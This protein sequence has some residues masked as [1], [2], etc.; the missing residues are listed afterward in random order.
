MVAQRQQCTA[1]LKNPDGKRGQ[2]I[3]RL[4]PIQPGG[5]V[6]LAIR[7]VVAVLRVPKL[8]TRAQQGCALGQQ[9]GGQ[10]C[11][12]QSAPEL[13]DHRIIAGAFNAAVEAEVIAMAVPVVFAIGFI[14]AMLVGHQIPQREAVVRCHVV[15]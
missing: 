10:Q 11:T 1:Q 14:A 8:G 5:G 9:S 2:V 12:L 6:V 15:H 4:R 3:I 7:V 13:K